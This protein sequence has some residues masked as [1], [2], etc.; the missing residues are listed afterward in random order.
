MGP[1][2]EL[3][4]AVLRPAGLGRAASALV[5]MLCSSLLGSGRVQGCYSVTGPLHRHYTPL[6]TRTDTN[7]HARSPHFNPPPSVCLHRGWRS[8]HGHW[9]F[10]ASQKTHD[11]LLQ[12]FFFFFGV[13]L[14]GLLFLCVCARLYM[15]LS[16]WVHVSWLCEGH[17]AKQ[18]KEEAA[19]ELL[20]VR[21]ECR[22]CVCVCVWSATMEQPF[23]V[24]NGG[25]QWGTF[26]K[27]HGFRD[28]FL[29]FGLLPHFFLFSPVAEFT[30]ESAIFFIAGHEMVH[31]SSTVWEWE[32]F[33]CFFLSHSKKKR[34]KKKSWKPAR[35]LM[36]LL[37]TQRWILLAL[38]R[39]LYLYS[40]VDYSI[41][42]W[43]VPHCSSGYN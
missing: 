41:F 30:M 31:F 14:S 42:F 37:N 7:T 28:L 35:Q 29:M 11:G 20:S 3:S 19:F 32:S 21:Y 17:E 12:F 38:R 22:A 34:K 10:D 1:C 8:R 4:C 24:L 23:A 5:L 25:N 18:M 33:S 16:E 27:W 43:M 9:Q 26:V 40:L 2:A 6:K 13:D 15:L 36:S 39:R